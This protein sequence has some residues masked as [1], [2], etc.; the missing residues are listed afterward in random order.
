MIVGPMP[1]ST[2]GK[3]NSRST[4]SEMEK[5]DNGYPKVI[6][7]GSNGLKISKSNFKELLE[8]QQEENYI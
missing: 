2:T 4:I 3:I 1:H 7:L 6:R 8:K 5:P